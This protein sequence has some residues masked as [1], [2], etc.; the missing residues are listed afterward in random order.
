MLIINDLV[1][2]AEKYQ[3]EQGSG[4]W[5]QYRK[6]QE[7]GKKI[8]TPFVVASHIRHSGVRMPDRI[9]TDNA[10][11]ERALE[12]AKISTSPISFAL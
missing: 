1:L 5:K 7:I 10:S 12:L 2:I 6:L 3:K 8:F 11:L 9:E 4:K